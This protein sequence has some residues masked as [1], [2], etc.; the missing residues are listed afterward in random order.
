M[1][2]CD[3]KIEVIDGEMKVSTKMLDP[4]GNVVATIDRNEWDAARRPVSWHRNFN[5]E[6]FEIMDNSGHVIL[7]VTVLSDRVRLQAIWLKRNGHRALLV[8]ANPR[9]GYST[10]IP[11]LPRE[12][13][14]GSDSY[15]QIP[16]M[17]L[18]PSENHLGQLA[19]PKR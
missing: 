14:D 17:F 5:D 4:N 7:Q 16:P 18:Y 10:W 1:K 6:S 13:F 15:L 2:E 8:Q 3:F 12:S 11:D 9:P 19:E